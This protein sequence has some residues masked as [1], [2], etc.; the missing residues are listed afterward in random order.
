ME[1]L[2]RDD[3]QESRGGTR[4]TIVYEQLRRE[5][6]SGR[7]LPGE[8]LRVE[9]LRERYGVGGSPLREAMNRLTAEGLV[10][11]LD[12]KGFRVSPVST[13]ELLELTR[14]RCW[15]NE[16]TLRESIT[17][18]DAAWEEQVLLAFHRRRTV[19]RKS[20]RW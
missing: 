7:L 4:T 9:V 1:S 12:Q 20:R 19:C 16:I 3:D 6:V 8:K 5:I 2:Q 11:Q 17:R 18:G 15:L 14:T 10:S 13:D